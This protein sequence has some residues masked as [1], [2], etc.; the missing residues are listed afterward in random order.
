MGLTHQEIEE[1][2]SKVG[3]PYWQI[4]YH[5]AGDL[6]FGL[7]L[8]DKAA[9]LRRADEYRLANLERRK[10]RPP[11]AAIL[12]FRKVGPVDSVGD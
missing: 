2:A 1:L 12:P 11:E 3:N 9:V 8:K 7:S 5:D 6:I 10:V 4:A